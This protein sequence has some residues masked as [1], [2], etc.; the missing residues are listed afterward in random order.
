MTWE[1]AAIKYPTV[2]VDEGEGS[3]S[4]PQTAVAAKTVVEIT[5]RGKFSRP[6]E[7]IL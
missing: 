6:A 4:T 1:K 5:S 7:P 2:Q 3:G